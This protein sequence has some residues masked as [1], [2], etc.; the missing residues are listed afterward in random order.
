VDI[1]KGEMVEAELDAMI[2]RQDERRRQSEGERAAEA[3]W[4][5]SVRRYNARCGEEERLERLEYHEGQIR[6]LSIPLEALIARHEAEAEK[7]RENGHTDENGTKGD[8]A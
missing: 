3:L 2:R 5:E 7:Y 6:R 1:A 8:A 4:V